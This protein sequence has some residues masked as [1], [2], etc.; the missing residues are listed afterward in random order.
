MERFATAFAPCGFRCE[1]FYPCYGLAEATLIVTGGQKAAVPVVKTVQKATLE[2]QQVIP[3][4]AESAGIRTLVSCGQALLDQQV[5]IVDP[6][7]RTRCQPGQV[8]EIWVRGPSVAQGYWNNPAATSQTFQAYIA[9][10]GEGP[11]LRTGEQRPVAVD[12][13][14][15]PEDPQPLDIDTV[16]STIRRAVAEQHGVQVYAVLLLRAGSIPK[17]SSGK[18]QRYACRTGFLTQSL[19]V[20]GNWH[21]ASASGPEALRGLGIQQG[22]EKPEE[23]GKEGKRGGWQRDRRPSTRDALRV[24]CL[25][26]INRL[27]SKPSQGGPPCGPAYPLYH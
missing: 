1:A 11:F 26:R 24:A 23:T 14:S 22:V 20:I 25:R 15:D 19:E 16:I 12:P 21:T 18:L 27:P 2:R 17:T 8:G 13:G 4:I 10:T 5:S 3:A 6:E 7:L 9:D